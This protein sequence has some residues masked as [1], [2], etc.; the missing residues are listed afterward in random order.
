MTHH[1]PVRI[2]VLLIT[3]P[4]GSGKSAVLTEVEHVLS[5]TGTR[6]AAVD[7]DALS[8][9][10]PGARRDPF[11]TALSLRNLAGLWRNFR[12]AGA[13]RLALACV[14]ESRRE[15]ARFRRAVPGAEITVVRLRAS[16]RALQSRVRQREIGL[17]RT[18]HVRRAAEL[19]RIMERARVEDVLVDTEARTINA[20]ARE[21]LEEAG[22]LPRRRSARRDRS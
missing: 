13:Q 6:F 14:V 8:G 12:A 22:W 7:L 21:V 2:P 17:G 3:G 15:L 11:N 19:A 18:W 1:A 16:I 5:R 4:V 10:H 9:C 20:I